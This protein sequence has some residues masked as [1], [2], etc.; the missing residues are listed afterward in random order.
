MAD[1]R[2]LTERLDGLADAYATGAVTLQQLT[3]AT[4]AIEAQIE[5]VR[6]K[7]AE[8]PQD[9][10]FSGMTLG[11]LRELLGNDATAREAL[12]RFTVTVH[13]IRRGTRRTPESVDVKLA[14]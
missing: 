14:H 10:Q 2:A 4:A 11:E 12:E 9:V 3:R 6:A 1:E 13:P 8:A 5:A 7:L